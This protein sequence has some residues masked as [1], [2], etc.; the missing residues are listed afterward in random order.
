MKN[1]FLF[2]EFIAIVALSISVLVLTYRVEALQKEFIERYQ[3]EEQS[4][5]DMF[6]SWKTRKLPH[7]N[8]TKPNLY[9]VI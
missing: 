3:L 6:D 8:A 7:F 9:G 2:V 1:L 4:N 5:R